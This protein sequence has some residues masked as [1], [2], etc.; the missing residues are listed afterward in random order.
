M[1]GNGGQ[2]EVETRV[3]VSQARVPYKYIDCSLGQEE[4]DKK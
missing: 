2:P 3:L 4:L 1:A